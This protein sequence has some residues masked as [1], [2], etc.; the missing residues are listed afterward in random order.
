M[1]L[2]QG[3]EA[4]RAYLDGDDAISQKKLADKLGV[5]QP[6]VSAWVSGSSR[7]ETHLR[8][9]LELLTGIPAESWKTEDE[10]AKVER[11]REGICAPSLKPTGTDGR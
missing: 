11:V 9:A 4:L 1:V 8:E 6:S 5:K 10:R 7:P 3:R 2:T